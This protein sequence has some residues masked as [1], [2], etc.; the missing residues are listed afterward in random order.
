MEIMND[1]KTE[2]LRKFYSTMAT[3]IMDGD[4]LDPTGNY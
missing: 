4:I 1:R 2:L 3:N